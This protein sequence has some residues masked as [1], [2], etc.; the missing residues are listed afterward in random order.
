MGS[1]RES[2]RPHISKM[3]KIVA[4]LALLA[5]VSAE[6]PMPGKVID[7][8]NKNFKTFINGERPAMVLF[9][10]TWCPHCKS[11]KAD[12]EAVAAAVGSDYI[13][14]RVDGET[15]GELADEYDISGYPTIKLLRADKQSGPGA[16]K[17][18]E[19]Y[20]GSMKATSIEQWLK[21]S[22]TSTQGTVAKLEM[23]HLHPDLE[24]IMSVQG[25]CYRAEKSLYVGH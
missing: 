3:M 11:M 13:I 20:E 16:A 5:L 8:T 17:Q 12:Y 23:K 19:E 2:T 10:A 24:S 1:K 22:A 14:G 15:Y 9:Y 7:M 18:S 25:K 21:S 6:H 4:A